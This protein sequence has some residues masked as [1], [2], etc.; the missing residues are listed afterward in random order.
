MQLSSFGHRLLNLPM[1]GYA[2]NL[3][4]LVQQFYGTFLEIDHAPVEQF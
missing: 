4:V 2:D 1:G 3:L